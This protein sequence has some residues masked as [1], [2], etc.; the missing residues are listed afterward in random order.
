MKKM[1]NIVQAKEIP[2]RDK[3]VWLRI[4]KAF[5]NDEGKIRLK[6]EVLPLPNGEGDVWLSLFEDDGQRQEEA[7]PTGFDAPNQYQAAKSGDLNDDI[8]W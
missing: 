5:E 1:Y 6:L 8:P 4:G 3:P 2:N 7:K